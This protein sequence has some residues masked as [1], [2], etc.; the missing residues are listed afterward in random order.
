MLGPL[1]TTFSQLQ[2]YLYE[3][4]P[5]AARMLLGPGAIAVRQRAN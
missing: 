4:T 3:L 1:L 5:R 2:V